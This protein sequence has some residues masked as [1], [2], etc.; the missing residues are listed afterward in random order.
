[1]TEHSHQ[2]L[3]CLKHGSRINLLL[4][5]HSA[6]QYSLPAGILVLALIASFDVGEML[7]HVT[8]AMGTL[9][10]AWPHELD[11]SVVSLSSI[12]SS[13]E[14]WPPAVQPRNANSLCKQFM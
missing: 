8:E 2:N 13:P 9:Q 5:E 1:M 6:C 10:P 4:S 7:W 14:N 12:V 11:L 3:L